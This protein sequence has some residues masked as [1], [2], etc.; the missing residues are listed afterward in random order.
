MTAKSYS[1]S[2]MCEDMIGGSHQFGRR[3]GGRSD[4]KKANEVESTRRLRRE[5]GYQ[6]ARLHGLQQS[7]DLALDEASARTLAVQIREQAG[8]CLGLLDNYQASVP[9]RLWSDAERKCQPLREELRRTEKLFRVNAGEWE[10]RST[11][12]RSPI[13]RTCDRKRD[14]EESGTR[15]RAEADHRRSLD[16]LMALVDDVALQDE[17][18]ATGPLRFALP[19]GGDP[20]GQNMLVLV[21]SDTGLVYEHLYGGSSCRR[22]EIE[23]FLVPA[24]AHPE[25]KGALDQLFSADLGGNGVRD[26]DR[27]EAVRKVGDAV[28]RIWYRGT[29]DRMAPLQIDEEL[30]HEMDEALV[31]VLTPDGPA[32]LV[33]TNSG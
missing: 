30:T 22:V 4:R 24:C 2:L 8:V 9:G 6:V 20:P 13:G 17:S 18:T 5:L 28:R 19:V 21:P 26:E 11:L 29:G 14:D 12:T 15:G 10:G 1:V 25:A 27:S 7:V 23:G 31:P 32:L 16:A 3:L 33:W